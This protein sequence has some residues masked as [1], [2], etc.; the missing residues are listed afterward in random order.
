MGDFNVHNENAVPSPKNNPIYPRVHTDCKEVAHH[1]WQKYPFMQRYSAYHRE[2]DRQSLA[3]ELFS[4]SSG[5]LFQQKG[6][7][8]KMY[9]GKP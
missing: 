9:P 8:T 6:E 5:T 3:Q 4:P 2:K 7:P 1:T